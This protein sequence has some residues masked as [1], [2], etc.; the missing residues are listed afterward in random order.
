MVLIQS[1]LTVIMAC[2]AAAAPAAWPGLLDQVLFQVSLLVHALL[3]VLCWVVPWKRL[4]PVATLSIPVGNVLALMLSRT[5]AVDFL[6]GL[7]ILMIF[8]VIW[9]A[10]SGR[11]PKSAVLLSFAVPLV[12]GLA[13]FLLGSA[14]ITATQLTTTVLMALM[15]LAVALTVRFVTATLFLQQ[16]Q[17]ERKDRELLSLLD[18]SK[19]SENLLKTVLDTIDVGITAVDATGRVV[20]RNRQQEVFERSTASP[21]RSDNDEDGFTLYGQD[22]KTRLPEDRM[23]VTRAVR[24]EVFADYYVWAGEGTGARALSTAARGIRTGSGDLAGAVVAYTDVTSL[25]ETVVAK[26]DL[27]ATVSHELRT[28]LTSVLGNLEFA[29]EQTDL[30]AARHYVDIA[31][32]GAERLVELLSDLLASNSAAMTVHPR[33]TDIAGLIASVVDSVSSQATAANIEIRTDVPAPLWTHTDPLRLG[34][35]LD[36]LL[37]N[38]IK[39]TPEGGMVAVRARTEDGHLRLD[40]RDT[41][42]GMSPLDAERVFDRF[43]RTDSAWASTIPGTGLGLSITKAIVEGHHGEISCRSQPGRGSTFTVSLPAL[44]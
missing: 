8:P 40:V 25:V 41:G 35:V 4:P 3:F 10:A 38:A 19:E 33:E 27:L 29:Q 22:R 31:H 5:G 23:P 37:S 9:L 16:R 26:D 34:Q 43:F 21:A 36:N 13:P 2:V 39:Y 14:R 7:S 44:T 28:P 32:R 30:H 42:M 12:M 6:P 17:L 20:L 1:P 11:F 15:L 18:S 24:G